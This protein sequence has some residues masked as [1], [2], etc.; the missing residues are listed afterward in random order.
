M[1]RKFAL[2]TQVEIH[3]EKLKIFHVCKDSKGTKCY[4]HCND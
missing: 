2:E 4:R 1:R 3:T